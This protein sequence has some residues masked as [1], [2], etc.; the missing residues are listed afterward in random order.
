M[1]SSNNPQNSPTSQEKSLGEVLTEAIEAAGLNTDTLSS[2]TML[3]RDILSD[4]IN[5]NYS[6][7]PALPYV[8][9]FL[10]TIARRLKLDPENLI[11]LFNREVNQKRESAPKKGGPELTPETKT[12]RKT[13]ILIISTLIIILLFTLFSLQKKKST[14]IF[15]PRVNSTSD[16]LLQVDKSAETDSVLQKTEKPPDTALPGDDA[17]VQQEEPIDSSPRVE[18]A[19]IEKPPP[20]KKTVVKAAPVKKT[21]EKPPPVKKTVVKTAPVKKTV[22][23][24]PPVKKTVVKTAPVPPRPAVNQRSGKPDA[25]QFLTRDQTWQVGHPD[26]ITIRFGVFEGVELYINGKTYVPEK[27]LVKIINGKIIE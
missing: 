7:L 2:E 24:P 6:N 25:N 12:S 1:N 26:T 19:K 18:P 9:A 17:T 11:T 16:T 22:E 21:V 14:S 4:L 3:S 8:R 5:G 20:V 27:R 10:M 15:S 13:P 23:K